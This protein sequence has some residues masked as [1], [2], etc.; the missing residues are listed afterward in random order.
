M[1]RRDVVIGKFGVGLKDA[2]ATLERNDIKVSII[3]KHGDISLGRS[4]KQGFSDVVTLHALRDEHQTQSSSEPNSSWN[5]LRVSKS[6]A[7]KISFF[8]SRVKS[9]LS[10]Q[11][12][13][14]SKAAQI[15]CSHLHQRRKGCG[16]T[17]V[18]LFLQHNVAHKTDGESLNRELTHVGRA[19]YTQRVKDILLECRESLWRRSSPKILRLNCDSLQ[20]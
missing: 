8:V 16:R 4:S 13:S 19:A 2:L 7:R 12:R 18:S 14:G 11:L 5:E 10:N 3:S 1:S 17:G 15:A 6:R 20:V 9:C